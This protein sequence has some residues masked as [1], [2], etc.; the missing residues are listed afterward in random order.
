MKKIDVGNLHTKPANNLCGFNNSLIVKLLNVK[1]Y[2]ELSLN[3]VTM[4]FC[5]DL[6]Y[7]NFIK[8]T[9]LQHNIFFVQPTSEGNQSSFTCIEFTSAKKHINEVPFVQLQ[10]QW[11]GNGSRAC[12]LIVRHHCVIV[13][14]KLNACATSS[15]ILGSDKGKMVDSRSWGTEYTRRHVHGLSNIQQLLFPWNGCRPIS[16]IVV[17]GTNDCKL[18]GSRFYVDESQSMNLRILSYKT[19]ILKICYSIMSTTR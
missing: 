14:S 18:D 15:C 11:D 17:G 5:T 3:K 12:D 4:C 8:W 6:N 7:F 10:S 13:P 9:S 19:I 2:I 1:I 16:C